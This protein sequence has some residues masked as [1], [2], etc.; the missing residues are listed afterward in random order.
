[1]NHHTPVLLKESIENLITNKSGLYFEGTIGFGGHSEVIL[2]QLNDN[3]RFI[4]TDKDIVAY[5]HCKNKF[6]ND[7]RVK[8]FNTS[9]T[10]IINVSKIEFI[11]KFDGIFVDLGVSSFQLDNKEAGF[12]YREDV[13]L[14]MRMNKAQ[15]N[16][17]AFYL[18]SLDEKEL[19][20]IFFKYG[21]ENNSKRIAKEICN[22]RANKKIKTSGELKEII[23]SITPEKFL[24]KTLTRIFQALRIYVNDELIELEDFLEKSISVL[25]KKGRLVVITFH[26]LEDRIVKNFFRDKTKDCICPVEYPVCVCNTK[27][28]LKLISRKPIIPGSEEIKINKRSRSAK[29]RVVEK[30]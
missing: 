24:I 19:V 29:L 15:G 5:E 11:D 3:A 22:Y 30:L 25:K 6:I 20:E 16:T 7:N 12:T 14:D 23:A 21:E 2:S 4:G 10:N 1:M 9:F 13:E 8:L 17:A 27:A 26:S 18:N 28:E